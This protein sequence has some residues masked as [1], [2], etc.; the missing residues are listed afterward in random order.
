MPLA[1]SNLAW[2]PHCHT[3]P[4]DLALSLHP[5]APE[6]Y[7]PQ[8]ACDLQMHAGITRAI[9]HSQLCKGIRFLFPALAYASS[10]Y[11]ST[12]L[13]FGQPHRRI[14]GQNNLP[15]LETK[16]VFWPTEESRQTHRRLH[17]ATASRARTAAVR[18]SPAWCVPPRPR[19]PRRSRTRAG[20]HLRPN[21]APRGPRRSRVLMFCSSQFVLC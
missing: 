17:R 5:L 6:A 11:S 16:L 14:S 3:V 21:G 4:T 7:L 12:H 13:A 19:A 1:H 2:P 8:D 15:R 20:H 18:S 10:S 9:A